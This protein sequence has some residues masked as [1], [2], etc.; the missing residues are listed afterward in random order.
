MNCFSELKDMLVFHIE[1]LHIFHCIT[2]MYRVVL[3]W[4]W[5]PVKH[6][7]CVLPQFPCLPEIGFFKL[8]LGHFSFG[9]TENICFS[10]FCCRVAVIRSREVVI[11][12]KLEISDEG[13]KDKNIGY[14]DVCCLSHNKPDTIS[15]RTA[16]QD[17]WQALGPGRARLT[18]HSLHH[19]KE[20]S[21][22]SF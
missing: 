18:T 9:G 3:K 4:P 22:C 7:Q 20:L 15:A 11:K 5:N 14:R 16:R 10:G 19:K 12:R 21:L 17:E 1:S 8:Y 2:V 13:N 6:Y